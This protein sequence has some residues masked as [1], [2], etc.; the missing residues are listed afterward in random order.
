MKENKK[1]MASFCACPNDRGQ[2][3]QNLK[4]GVGKRSNAH[5][6]KSGI[7]LF[8]SKE[9]GQLYRMGYLVTEVFCYLVVS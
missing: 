6:N 3:K 8:L 1:W 4:F 7:V 5:V 9:E 2:E